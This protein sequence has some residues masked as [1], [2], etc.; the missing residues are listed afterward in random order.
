[1]SLAGSGRTEAFMIRLDKLS[2]NLQGKASA[3]DLP[4]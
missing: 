2:P 4:S 3:H 1:M